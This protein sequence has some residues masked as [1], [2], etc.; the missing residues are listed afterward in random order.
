MKRLAGGAALGSLL[1]I[2]AC[3]QSNT[4]APPPPPQVT[5]AKPVRQL[6]A[7]YLEF[8]GN[9]QAI[10]TVQLVA[11]VQG[12][13]DKILFKDGDMVK[14]GQLL[15]L[16][17][18]DTYQYQLNQAE[19]Q[20]LQNKANWEHAV[21]ETNRYTKL[22]QQ[23]A[24]AQTDLDNWKYQRDA[25]LAAMKQAQAARDLAKLNLGYARVTAPFNGRMGRHLVDV[26]NLVGPG[27]PTASVQPTA[28]GQTTSSGPA[29]TSGQSTTSGQATVLAEINQIDPLYVYFTINEQDLYRVVGETGLSP[30]R[31][32]NLKI[33]LY[34]GLIN[35]AG[36]PHKG[37]LDFAAISLTPTTGTLSLRGIFPNPDGKIEAGSFARIKAPVEG[38]RKETILV[39][40]VA[41]GYD[42]Q[43][44]YVL[45]VGEN[46]IVQRQGVEIG[47]K[48]GD[49]R[50]IEG[51]LKGDES[52]VVSGML[53]A[54]PGRPVKPV[55]ENQ[56]GAPAER[57]GKAPGATPT[58]APAATPAGS[59]AAPQGDKPNGTAAT[60][61][62]PPESA[63]AAP[64]AEAPAATQAPLAGNPAPGSGA[65]QGKKKIKSAS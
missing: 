61:A 8:T 27:Q 62:E 58:P 15:F 29:I 12:Y 17:Q 64:R 42:Q 34:L 51:G 54:I 57:Q 11:R 28:S 49:L 4:Y 24:A 65:P 48:V 33:P 46:N 47:A 56:G 6:V 19:A 38:S 30:A 44:P 26:G 59:Q 50:A 37:Y 21:I 3:G 20:I 10:N 14:K 22:V 31:A 43:G 2:M 18:Q 7:D 60:T 55:M 25:Y 45:V 5:V 52:V 53:K 1:V 9:T 13:L 35:E 32:Q 39:P 16:I 63:A 36:Y 41:V 23:K 40:D